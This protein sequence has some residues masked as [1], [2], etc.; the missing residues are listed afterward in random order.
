MRDING[1]PITIEPDRSKNYEKGLVYLFRYDL[2]DFKSFKQSM[3]ERFGL[4]DVEEAFWV[5]PQNKNNK[6]LLL[7]FGSERP[8]CINIPGEIMYAKVYE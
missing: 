7:T 5:K 8:N 1:I 3:W 6:P 4:I 2:S